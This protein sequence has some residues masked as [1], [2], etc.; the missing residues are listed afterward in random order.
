MMKIFSSVPIAALALFSKSE[1]VSAG[2]WKG[3]GSKSSKTAEPTFY[4]TNS[5]TFSPTLSPTK[6]GKSWG[7][8]DDDDDDDD[9]G[10]WKKKKRGTT[11]RR[12]GKFGQVLHLQF[13]SLPCNLTMM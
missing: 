10:G 3:G 5:P 9:W 12:K 11:K 1:T 6:S 8:W 7:G 2:G 4:P 13:M